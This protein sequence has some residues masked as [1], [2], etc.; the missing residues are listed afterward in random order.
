MADAE[1]GSG[2]IFS[3]FDPND[4]PF[5]FNY[6]VGERFNAST[7]DARGF[8]VSSIPLRTTDID[9]LR[10]ADKVWLIFYMDL[11]KEAYPVVPGASYDGSCGRFEGS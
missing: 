11:E 5:P 6:I 4:K 2:Q 7:S 10:Q 1:Y 9:L 8:Y 3:V